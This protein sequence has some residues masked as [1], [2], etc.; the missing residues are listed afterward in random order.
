[1]SSASIGAKDRE[2]PSLPDLRKRSM[3]WAALQNLQLQG[4]RSYTQLSFDFLAC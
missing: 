3:Y 2:A 4:P 1:M